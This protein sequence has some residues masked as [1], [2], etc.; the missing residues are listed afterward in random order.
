[1]ERNLLPD[2]KLILALIEVQKVLGPIAVNHENIFTE[3]RYLD[4]AEILQVARPVLAEHGVLLQQTAD[5][6]MP[7]DIPGVLVM[8]ELINSDGEFIR[9]FGR[10]GATQMHKANA[11][12]MLGASIS[13]LRRFQALTVLGIAGA[14]D[15]DEA[16][17]KEGAEQKEAPTDRPGPTPDDQRQQ[18]IDAIWDLAADRVFTDADRMATKT[19]YMNARTL[20]ALQKVLADTHAAYAEK[21]GSTK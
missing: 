15:D 16:D 12:Q 5:V 14:E 18:I 11:T 13:Y 3:T 9:C 19:S 21:G 6:V 2:S 1:M 17:F 4:L 10:L 20:P 8:T 7:N